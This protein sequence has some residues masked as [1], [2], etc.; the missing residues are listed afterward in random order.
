MKSGPQ[1]AKHSFQSDEIIAHVSMRSVHNLK[2]VRKC[3]CVQV[4]N[5]T[6]EGQNPHPL[7]FLL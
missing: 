5:E 4:P 1:G 2:H 6:A 3:F 7:S